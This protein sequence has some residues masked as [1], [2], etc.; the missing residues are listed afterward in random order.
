MLAPINGRR[1]F[2]GELVGADG[3]CVRLRCSDG[4]SEP[5]EVLL[6]IED[7]AEARLVLTDALVSESLRRSKHGER[8][9]RDAGRPPPGDKNED[10]DHALEQV[11]R[12]HQPDGD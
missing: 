9:N 4:A 7:M 6:R 5:D 11:R 1:R 10:L 2:R 8:K 12:A 3:E